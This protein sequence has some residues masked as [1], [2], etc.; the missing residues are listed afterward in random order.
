MS[1]PRGNGQNG[2]HFYSNITQ[3][4]ELLLN[5]I[6]DST[7]G[8][9]LGVRSVKSNGYVKNVF[10]HT[11]APLSGSGNPN[12]AAGHVLIQLNNN[13]NVY[14]GGNI[15]FVSPVTG[16]NLTSTTAGV[17]YVIVSLGTT[18]LAQWQA[19]GLPAGLT[20]ALGQS[21]VALATGAIGGTGAVKVVATSGIASMEVI[22]NPTASFNNSN[23][24]ANGG[25]YLLLQALDFAGAVANPVDGTV[26][27]MSI[28][29]DASSVTI[30]GL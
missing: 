23:I 17:S 3:P 30:D 16:S 22:G 12:P 25:A 11:T 5:F 21:F 9:G 28:I 18:T 19:A 29:V 1:V 7:N 2:G 15:G 8:N 10:M 27:G 14:L 4:V 24:A 13:Y 26:V 6:V 20:P